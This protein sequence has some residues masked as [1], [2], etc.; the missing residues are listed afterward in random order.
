M[1]RYAYAGL[2]ALMIIG[3]AMIQ[4]GRMDALKTAKQLQ[5]EA[6]A[7]TGVFVQQDTILTAYHVIKGYRDIM[8]KYDGRWYIASVITTDSWH[9]L[10]LIH[11]TSGKHTPYASVGTARDHE[12][13]TIKGYDLGQEVL[14]THRV[15][16]S[17][18]DN[19]S[20]LNAVRTN[21][22]VCQGDSG[23]AAFDTHNQIVGLTDRGSTERADVTQPGCSRLSWLIKPEVIRDFLVSNGIV[24]TVNTS[25]ITPVYIVN[26]T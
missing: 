5:G 7:G 22:E 20:R 23:S 2:T 13:I 17:F 15:W 12:S 26:D 16:F 10:A 25:T 18:E 11:I 24:S 9:D 3:L 4:Y 8:V 14:K 6:F 1:N 21:D 19:Q